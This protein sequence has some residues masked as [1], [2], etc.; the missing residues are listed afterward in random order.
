MV[1][2]ALHSISRE[3]NSKVFHWAFSKLQLLEI[4]LVILFLESWKS[5]NVVMICWSQLDSYRSG[6]IPSENIN[7]QLEVDNDRSP[8]PVTPAAPVKLHS[9][10][11]Q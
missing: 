10:R 6:C 8:V 3:H 2:G 4:V 1:G 7:N 5:F 11:N 9:T